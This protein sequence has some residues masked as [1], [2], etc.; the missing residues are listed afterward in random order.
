LK[1]LFWFLHLFGLSIW[2]GSFVAMAICLVSLR[3]VNIGTEV[4]QLFNK[5]QRAI[6][7]VGNTGAVIML[8]SGGVLLS[9]SDSR[10]LWVVLMT[11]IGGLTII[12]SII[13]VTL[14][15]R[16]LSK[17]LALNEPIETLHREFNLLNIFLWIVTIVIATVLGIVSSRI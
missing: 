14:Q 1:H 13:A 10:P 2:M 11:Q 17:R 12:F 9:L 3:K 4:M 8:I 16:R 6:T 15:S 5:A 7:I